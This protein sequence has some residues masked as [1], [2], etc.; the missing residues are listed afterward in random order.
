MEVYLAQPRGFCAGVV[1]AI[2]IV[3]RALQ[4]YGPPVYVRH[5]IVH[6]KY[7]VES[8]KNKG[9]IFV[10]DLSEVPPLAVTEVRLTSF[11]G[12][13]YSQGVLLQWKTG[14][15][16]DN[17]GFNIYREINGVR[18]RLNGTLITGSGLQTG[19]GVGEAG[20]RTYARWDL[21]QAAGDPTVTYWLEDVEFN[22]KTTWHGPITPV[23]GQLNETTNSAA[24]SAELGAIG[25][26]AAANSRQI[27]FNYNEDPIHSGPRAVP[28]QVAP[29]VTQQWAL[30][31][32]ATVKLGIRKPGWYRVPQS[33]LVAA[34]LG[35]SIDPH[36]LQLFVDGT[37][38]AI[39]VNG[40]TDGRSVEQ[41]GDQR[42]GAAPRLGR[43]G[44]DVVE[45]ESSARKG[46]GDYRALS[47]LST[48]DS[49]AGSALLAA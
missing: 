28:A 37:E 24:D 42:G 7:V 38:Q 23:V 26:D 21:D 22:G 43:C 9:A 10:E 39:R 44:G 8:L 16:I 19:Q 3:E 48:L 12:A 29:Q 33:D 15:E 1:R 6:N 25:N 2:E 46:G 49:L 41:E 11:T 17:L 18:T 35:S 14:Y 32:Q 4:K 27:F 40:E 36:T 30:A 20:L 31:S 13:R 45:H 34:G 47:G 5:E